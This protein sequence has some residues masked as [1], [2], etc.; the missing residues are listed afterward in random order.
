VPSKASSSTEPVR[1]WLLRAHIL[2]DLG[3]GALGDAFWDDAAHEI[4]GSVAS[5]LKHVR[6]AR[7][8]VL[9]EH[10]AVLEI[11]HQRVEEG[12]VLRCELDAD[13]RVLADVD[14]GAPVDDPSPVGAR[15]RLVLVDVGAR[16]F[17]FELQLRLRLLA[18]VPDA[19]GALRVAA[20]RAQVVAREG[21]GETV[22][23]SLDEHQRGDE[24]REFCR[25]T[26]VEFPLQL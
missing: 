7:G 11:V 17:L 16:L 23:R 22:L 25:R 14:G 6:V 18:P 21:C 5:D 13:A 2:D 9:T 26:T 15:P 4:L 1:R 10:A 24:C 8:G 12:P 19:F 3:V 20:Q